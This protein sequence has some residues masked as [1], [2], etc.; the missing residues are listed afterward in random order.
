MSETPT[1]RFFLGFINP[2]LF[3]AY[4]LIVVL[5]AIIFGASYM[6]YG[7]WF[8]VGGILFLLLIPT[9]AALLLVVVLSGWLQAWIW[10]RLQKQSEANSNQM[11][12][13]EVL[14]RSCLVA[15]LIPFLSACIGGKFCEARA[16]RICD[17]CAPLI[18]D[19]EKEKKLSGIYPTNAVTLVRS[20][21]VLHRRYLFYYGVPSTNSVDWIPNKILQA[22]ISLFVTTNTFQCVVPIERMSPISFSSFYVFSYSSEHPAWNKVLLHWSM[23]GAYMDEPGK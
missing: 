13:I 9:F 18:A 16:H 15:L 20:N 8:R 22:H 1:K 21:T 10:K 12:L 7:C 4:V 5:S 17:D 14:W 3:G 6:G 2:S 23:F 11:P 19:L